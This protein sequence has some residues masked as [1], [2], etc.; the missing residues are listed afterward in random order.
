MVH[1]Y[2]DLFDR[3]SQFIYATWQ[4]NTINK[5]LLKFSCP[6]LKL[7]HPP[8]PP[9]SP[10]QKGKKILGLMVE[11]S[12]GWVTLKKFFLCVWFLF[13]YWFCLT[14][15]CLFLGTGT[16]RW[17]TREPSS[18]TRSLALKLSRRSRTTTRE[19]N[20]P[21]HSSSR[22]LSA[23]PP[24]EISQTARRRRSLENGSPLS[25]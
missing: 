20:P 24:R 14:M 3:L 8:L 13:S 15:M 11:T 9:S 7:E 23:P 18:S 12:V 5:W 22:R 21:T 2:A 1:F 10:P 6:N 17:T 16:C 25:S 4:K 19:S